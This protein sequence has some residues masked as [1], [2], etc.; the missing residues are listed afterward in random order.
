[1]GTIEED[2][3]LRQLENTML[4]SVPLR[5]VKGINRVFLTQQDAVT[6]TED[7]SIWVEKGKEWVPTDGALTVST[8]REH[9][10]TA[11]CRLASFPSHLKAVLLLCSAHLLM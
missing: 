4:N 8:S 9:I 3:F 7:G 1:M 6:I 11:V 10:L 2:I 5:G